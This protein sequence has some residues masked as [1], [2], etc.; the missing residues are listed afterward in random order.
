VATRLSTDDHRY[1]S[2]KEFTIGI[3]EEFQLIDLE[4]FS[5]ASV[6]DEILAHAPQDLLP[7]LQHEL[8]QAE[9]EINTGICENVS[10][11]R[12]D[13]VSTRKRIRELVM[14]RG[15]L[16]AATGTHPFSRWQDQKITE[17]PYYLRLVGELQWWARQ[18]NSFGQHVH[19]GVNSPEKAIQIINALRSYVPH[20]LALSTNSPF[21]QGEATG[22]KS[23]RAQIFNG[24]FL[25]KGV[26]PIF[27]DWRE[28]IE[29]E[30]TLEQTNCIRERGE[31]WWDI[32]P[33]RTYGTI[34]M[35][36]CD[37][38]MRVD[39]T[40]ALAA[41]IQALIR[42]F[43]KIYEEGRRLHVQ[44]KDL[45]DENKWRAM[46]YGLAGKFIEPESKS[47]I[48]TTDSLKRL[49]Q[50]LGQE[51]DE[52]GSAREFAYLES[53]VS[54][55]ATGAD[56]LLKFYAGNKDFRELMRYVVEESFGSQ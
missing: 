53:R 27:R 32:R 19:I 47:E 15:Y 52:L 25:R 42:R 21:W 9:I 44:P 43:S 51:I 6:V 50:W 12:A 3:E 41:L 13:I 20:L 34:E 24:S 23:T 37:V 14:E 38:Q 54:E 56:R 18:N 55:K 22:L 28:Y 5:L 31:I 7:R 30:D 11:A 46:R 35:R 26:P 48:L 4:N 1:G 8:I 2:S 45:I 33:N 40:I 49:F 10:E 29:L 17:Q 36:I 16:L 39:E